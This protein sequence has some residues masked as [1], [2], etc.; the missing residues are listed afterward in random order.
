MKHCKNPEKK[1]LRKTA[2]L[3]IGFADE[4]GKP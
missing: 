2:I 4:I 3:K 1:N